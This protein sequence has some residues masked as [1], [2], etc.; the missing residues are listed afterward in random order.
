MQDGGGFRQ[1]EDGEREVQ[2][3]RLQFEGGAV[4][5]RGAL[6]AQ[7]EVLRP[8]GRGHELPGVAGCDAGGLEC[9]AREAAGGCC[10]GVEVGGLSFGI[11]HP[12]RE[13][14]CLEAHSSRIHSIFSKGSRGSGQ[15]VHLAAYSCIKIQYR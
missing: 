10:G 13:Q 12:R 5:G 4:A 9:F 7:G 15:C 2:D 14:S 1:G 11:V 6:D 8:G 3:G